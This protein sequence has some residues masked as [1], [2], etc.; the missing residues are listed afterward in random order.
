MQISK[1]CPYCGLINNE[2]T[3]YCIKCGY[4]LSDCLTEKYTLDKHCKK[5]IFNKLLKSLKSNH[6]SVSNDKLSEKFKC[7]NCGHNMEII[8]P[9][10]EFR[11]PVVYKCNDCQCTITSP[12]TSIINESGHLIPSWSKQENIISLENGEIK[13][14]GKIHASVGWEYDIVYPRDAFGVYQKVI[15]HH[16][17]MMRARMCGGDE[18]SVEYIL[19][20]LKYGLFCIT[21]EVH[22]RGALEKKHIHYYLVE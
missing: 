1:E 18:A 10:M 15:Y 11:D 21:E 19:K 22:F 4:P 7:T 3:I 9:A 13:L 2:E 5:N 20:P 6:S 17:E 8:L 14:I 12:G 16:P